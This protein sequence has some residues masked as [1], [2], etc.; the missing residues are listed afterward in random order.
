MRFVGCNF[1][2]YYLYNPIIDED[3][4]KIKS[5]KFHLFFLEKDKK[6]EMTVYE[7]I[8]KFSCSR[9]GKLIVSGIKEFPEFEF[10]AN[11]K[12]NNDFNIDFRKKNIKCDLFKFSSKKIIIHSDI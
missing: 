9:F 6:I 5:H 4:D 11:E 12:L 3:E 2:E 1:E 8:N 10:R 7:K